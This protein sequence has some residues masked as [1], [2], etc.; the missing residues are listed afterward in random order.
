MRACRLLRVLRRL[1]VCLALLGL[2]LSA[3]ASAGVTTKRLVITGINAYAGVGARAVFEGEMSPKNPP[4]FV[5]G[6]EGT[7]LQ[8]FGSQKLKLIAT[9]TSRPS[10]FCTN[11]SAWEIMS[12]ALG[13]KGIV[14]C[15]TIGGG[16]SE[17]DVAVYVALPDGKTT[18]PVGL[19]YSGGGED[20]TPGIKP[21]L[22]PALLGDGHFFGYL[23]IASGGVVQLF[24]ITTA[25]KAEYVADLTGLSSCGDKDEVCGNAA[26]D[27]G[28]IV[29]RQA[30]SSDVHVFTTAGKPIAT[31]T[32]NVSPI[33][34][35]VAIRKDRIVTLNAHQLTV[36]T[37]SGELVRSHPVQAWVGS[38]VSTYYGYAAYVGSGGTSVYVLKLSSG[39]THEIY[40]NPL[41]TYGI[42]RGGSFSLQQS[43]LSVGRT[44]RT[45]F[46][47][48]PWKKLRAKFH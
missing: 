23:Q 42:I 40:R 20:D 17:T 8:K 1:A 48:V 28:H 21:G 31:F 46:V 37:L 29:I 44:G 4:H 6:T 36:Y 5:L 22:V 15:L 34:G 3:S 33:S 18:H 25:G 10:G 19:G 9:P 14:G 24:R 43:G 11:D 13:P 26:V 39:E 16:I 2:A 30:S 41:S 35:T 27:S 45:G 47:Y 38:A 32:A 7:W 12:V